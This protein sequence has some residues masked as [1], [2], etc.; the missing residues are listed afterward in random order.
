MKIKD[1]YKN[2]KILITG[3]TGF[4]GTWLSLI[5]QSFGANLCGIGLEPDIQYD[6]LFQLTRLS[7]QINSNIADIRNLNNIRKIIEDFQPEI[8]FHLAAQPF[9]RRSYNNPIETWETNVMGTLNLFEAT[10][11]LKF[12]KS[13]VNITTDKCYENKEWCW[14][15]KETDQ[16][17]GHDPYSASKAAVEIL[18][19]S[20]KNS[21][22]K[23]RN[24]QMAT[25]RA[26]NVIGGGDFGED[27]LIPSMIRSIQNNQSIIIRKPDAVR[28]WQHVLEA[29][30]GYLL[31]GEKLYNHK[32]YDIAY[33][34]GPDKNE[35]IT[36]LDIVRYFKKQINFDY[37]INT[38]HESVHEAKL[39]MLDN[40][41]AK[42]MLKWKPTLN[43][44]QSLEYTIEW[45]KNYISNNETLNI[46]L[47]Q[48]DEFFTNCNKSLD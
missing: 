18:S 42:D 36:V 13:V 3:H 40:S 32:N 14:S 29:L 35:Q 24:I 30:Y 38:E 5:L 6:S 31:V 45:Y 19:S 15:Y 11:N 46:T 37:I 1:F 33:N 7:L 10:K 25:V 41:L 4:K 48:I 2:K 28:P 43:I 39:L 16:L 34:F 20:Y 9:V 8:I 12:L 23:E 27:R 17:G 44:Q 22:F 26:G 21:F 47:T